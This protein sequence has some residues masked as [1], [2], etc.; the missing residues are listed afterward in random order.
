MDQLDE[1]TEHIEI[2]YSVNIQALVFTFW[3]KI[4]NQMEN[5]GIY[6][7]TSW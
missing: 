5:P 6:S 7:I 4:V 2:T 3:L 1:I